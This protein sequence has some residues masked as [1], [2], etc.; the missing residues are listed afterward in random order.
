[1]RDHAPLKVDNHNLVKVPGLKHLVIMV[2]DPHFVL[3]H[4]PPTFR[5][6]PLPLTFRRVADLRVPLTF[7]RVVTVTVE[8]PNALAPGL[9]A[10]QVV[11]EFL[12]GCGDAFSRT[13]RRAG[14][15]ADLLRVRKG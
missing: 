14:H 4:R 9:L 5:R 13:T 3:K 15:V 1:M 12:A 7:R 8:A 2:V 11:T 6:V 10:Q